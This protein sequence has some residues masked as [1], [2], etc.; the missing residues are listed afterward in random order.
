MDDSDSDCFITFEQTKATLEGIEAQLAT[1]LGLTGDVRQQLIALDQ[2][3]ELDE[4]RL[5]RDWHS[6]YASYL[7]WLANP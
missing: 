2:R 7:D 3:N 4:D 1:R 6:E 5:V